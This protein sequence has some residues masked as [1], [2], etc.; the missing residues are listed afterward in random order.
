[1]KDYKDRDGGT[2]WS[3]VYGD[4]AHL[5]ARHAIQ[6]KIPK[7]K[8]QDIAIELL[9]LY[10]GKDKGSQLSENRIKIT[11]GSDPKSVIEWIENMIQVGWQLC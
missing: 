5:K 10:F 6:Q 7:P 11:G 3:H 8:N 4:L 9:N 2:N 1:M